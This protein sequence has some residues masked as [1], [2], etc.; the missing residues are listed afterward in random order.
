[1]KSLFFLTTL[2]L[3]LFACDKSNEEGTTTAPKVGTLIDVTI[4]STNENGKTRVSYEPNGDKSIFTVSWTE[5]DEISLSVPNT[6]GNDNQKFMATT[7]ANSSDL[8]GSIATW[9]GERTVYAVYPF[10]TDGYTLNTENSSINFSTTEQIID[11]TASNYSNGLM[12]ATSNG[13]RAVS[14][15]N[16]NIPNLTFKQAVSFFQLELADIPSGETITEIAFESTEN[17]FISSTDIN[18]TNAEIVAGTEVKTNKIIAMVENHIGGTATLNFAVLPID[19]TG[20]NI[21]LS[22]STKNGTKK[23]YTKEFVNGL[24]FERNTFLYSASGALSLINDFQQGEDS[25][26]YFAD[27]DGTFIPEGDT[28]VIYDETGVDTDFL[29]LKSAINLSNKNVSLKFPNLTSIPSQTFLEWNKITSIDCPLVTAIESSTFE[30]C[31]VLTTALF[32]K[33]TAIGGSAFRGCAVLTTISFPEITSIEYGAFG[34]CRL[35]KTVSFPKAITINNGAFNG[36]LALTEVSFPEVVIINDAVFGGCIALTEVSFPKATTIG[37]IAFNGCTALTTASFPMVTTIGSDTFGGCVLT[38]L[39]LA[40]NEGVILEYMGSGI[41]LHPAE[42]TNQEKN[43]VLTI[44]YSNSQNINDNTLTVTE[45][46]YTFKKII[47]SGGSETK[48]TADIE[49]AGGIAW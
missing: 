37:G 5:Y 28:W 29:K 20:K 19:L 35:L 18:L 40:T 25:K 49:N 11:I 33:A 1:M 15:E 44:G 2:T 46:S 48:A 17:I 41:F 45:Q 34:D 43:I 14:A 42:L 21:T 7:S 47:V 27:F 16:Y 4:S 6:V 26:L 36:C 9:E 39:E 32:P 13:T 3:L 30:Y 31:E 38:S 10:K 22:I 23:I 8:T 24:N 12:I